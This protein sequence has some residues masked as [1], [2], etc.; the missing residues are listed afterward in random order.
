M[1]NQANRSKD[2]SAI[3]KKKKNPTMPSKEKQRT[4]VNAAKHSNGADG[5][6]SDTGSSANEE[7]KTASGG[8]G[9]D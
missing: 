4:E 8:S 7:S 3:V 9:N 5:Q 2:Q 1:P 6:K